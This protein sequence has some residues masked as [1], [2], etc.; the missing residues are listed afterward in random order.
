MGS[1]ITIETISKNF[2]DTKVLKDILVL[3]YK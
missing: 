3:E 1:T 2:K